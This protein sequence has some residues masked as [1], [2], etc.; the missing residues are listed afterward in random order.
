[1]RPK[2]AATFYREGSTCLMIAWISLVIS[3][4]DF[5][6]AGLL[7]GSISPIRPWISVKLRHM[8]RRRQRAP[9]TLLLS[10]SSCLL[11]MRQKRSSHPS[12]TA[13]LSVCMS[14]VQRSSTSLL[15]TLL[16]TRTIFC[17]LPV[18]SQSAYIFHVHCSEKY[19]HVSSIQVR[20]Q[21]CR[22]VNGYCTTPGSLKPVLQ[23]ERAAAR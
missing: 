2:I 12:S 16:M 10:Q 14:N 6:G 7:H 5:S 13:A 9:C 23:S 20:R 4:C 18:S 19:T 8:L 22:Y 1:M 3:P 21:G 15:A 11:G 17:R